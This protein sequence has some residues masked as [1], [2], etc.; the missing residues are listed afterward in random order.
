MNNLLALEIKSY[1]EKRII[2]FLVHSS[3]DT[4]NKFK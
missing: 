1:Y 2:I 3:F 4:K